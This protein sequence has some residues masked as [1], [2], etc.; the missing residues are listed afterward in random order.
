LKTS[1]KSSKDEN[2]NIWNEKYTGWEQQFTYCREKRW[3]NIALDTIQ[4]EKQNKNYRKNNKQSVCE[5]W[6][7]VK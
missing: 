2:Y 7:H 5:L 1:T 4:N 3:I 6:D